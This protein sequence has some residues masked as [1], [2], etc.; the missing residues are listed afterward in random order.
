MD[1]DAP[2]DSLMQQDAFRQTTRRFRELLHASHKVLIDQLAQDINL[3]LDGKASEGVQHAIW[4]LKLDL[5]DPE[6]EHQ[7]E[8]QDLS[9]LVQMIA[10][11]ARHDPVKARSV[12]NRA[13]RFV[14]ERIEQLGL[15]PL[16]K[17]RPWTQQLSSSRLNDQISEGLSLIN[18]RLDQQSPVDL[19]TAKQLHEFFDASDASFGVF[20]ITKQLMPRLIE[21]IAGGL[22]QHDQMAVRDLLTGWDEWRHPDEDR[23]RLF[24][25]SS[26]N[27][28]R[29]RLLHVHAM[30]DDPTLDFGMTPAGLLDGLL[31]P[32]QAI[33]Q[34][35][36][37]RSEQ[38]DRV[39]LRSA[40]AQ[41]LEHY[42]QLVSTIVK[43]HQLPPA[44]QKQLATGGDGQIVRIH[45]EM[46]VL[47]DIIEHTQPASCLMLEERTRRGQDDSYS[48]NASV[49]V[50]LEVAGTRISV[51]AF[52]PLDGCDQLEP[53]QKQLQKI[54]GYPMQTLYKIDDPPLLMEH[55]EH[56]SASFTG[57]AFP[58]EKTLSLGDIDE[59]VPRA[60]PCAHEQT[61]LT[62]HGHMTSSSCVM[63]GLVL[64]VKPTIQ[65]AI[66]TDQAGKLQLSERSQPSDDAPLSVQNANY[67]FMLERA[68]RVLEGKQDVNSLEQ[69]VAA[70]EQDH[71][72]SLRPALNSMDNV[73]LQHRAAVMLNDIL[74]DHG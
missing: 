6:P 5:V 72:D 25:D 68:Y 11:L 66:Y 13:E 10:I 35:L 64:D 47:K 34:H 23:E 60:G 3:V 17:G 51:F 22:E 28:L 19:D 67:V 63:C 7:D 55:H 57:R 61:A 71:A 52:A 58:P 42:A 32:Q 9:F 26:S 37:K 69:L 30:F 2:I 59:L 49:R 40:T 45:C 18:K 36:D 29:A 50:D 20:T 8:I 38:I 41:S 4:S 27:E 56:Q 43:H 73:D 15:E 33:Q 12:I 62:E 31:D 21:A 65:Y 16:S 24:F 44:P 46:H 70:W 48:Y 14:R 74:P 1:S 53:A 54:F 39:H